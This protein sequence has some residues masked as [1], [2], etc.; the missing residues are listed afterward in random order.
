MQSVAWL[1]D[2][3]SAP[4]LLSGNARGLRAFHH[5]LLADAVH[6]TDKAV[7]VLD[8]AHCI[9]PHEIGFAHLQ[10][11]HA[12]DYAA[13]RVL[14]RRAMTPFQWDACMS[15]DLDAQFHALDVGLVLAA[16]IDAQILRDEIT[17]WEQE[18]YLAA[19]LAW[20]KRLAAR[21]AVPILWSIDMQRF[22]RR[23]PLLAVQLRDGIPTTRHIEVEGRGWRVTNQ[24]GEVLM[25]PRMAQRRITDY[26]GPDLHRPLAASVPMARRTNPRR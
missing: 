16:P 2:L 3:P 12:A 8:G 15:E 19:H 17:D 26:L 25:R 23:A 10:H 11:G 20:A 1:A 22:S 21:H 24:D 7:L 13:D 5:A 6:A 18:A 4:V 14:I 9:N